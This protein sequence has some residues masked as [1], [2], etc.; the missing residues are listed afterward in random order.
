MTRQKA[1]VHRIR[2]ALNEHG[3]SRN[4]NGHACAAVQNVIWRWRSRSDGEDFELLFK[5]VRNKVRATDSLIFRVYEFLQ[6]L[7][8]YRF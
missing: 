6:T 2:G 4:R 8:I 7:E 3:I 1:P 5:C